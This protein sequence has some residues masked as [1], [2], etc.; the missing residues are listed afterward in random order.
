MEGVARAQ[1]RRALIR[2]ARGGAKVLPP[3]SDDLRGDQRQPVELRQR[4]RSSVAVDL[5][6]TR[7]H[8]KRG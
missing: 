8:R 3:N 2:E 4:G 7:L 5:A 6:C 1:N